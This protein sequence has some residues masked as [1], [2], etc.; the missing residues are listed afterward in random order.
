MTNNLLQQPSLGL[1]IYFDRENGETT[2]QLWFD[3]MCRKLE[4]D[5]E[6]QTETNDRKIGKLDDDTK[7]HQVVLYP[8]RDSLVVYVTI[9]LKQDQPVEVWNKFCKKTMGET[10]QTWQQL[11]TEQTFWGLSLFFVG[12]VESLSLSM[13]DKASQQACLDQIPPIGQKKRTMLDKYAWGNLWQVSGT[14]DDLSQRFPQ[15]YEVLFLAE[16]APQIQPHLINFGRSSLF[17]IEMNLH[18]AYHQLAQFYQLRS[19]RNDEQEALEK[20]LQTLLQKTSQPQ[21]IDP[22]SNLESELN[23]LWGQY[24][25]INKYTTHIMELART[26]KSNARNYRQTSERLGLLSSGLIFQNHL[27]RLDLAQEQLD[28]DKVYYEATLKRFEVGLQT[29]RTNLEISRE[30]RQRSEDK[31]AENL[32]LLLTIIGVLLALTQLYPITQD[33]M[34]NIFWCSAEV[35]YCSSTMRFWYDVLVLILFVILSG[36]A[37]RWWQG[38]K[39]RETG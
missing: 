11:R 3:K 9:L 23:R 12:M 16:Q 18:K 34:D 5:T 38:N 33:L 26:L 21:A 22:H 28:A 31:R 13:P 24:V 15:V 39:P 25:V 1:F 36:W 8:L 30:R 29:V 37:Y 35:W 20:E 6:N 17:F 19:T 27:E 7:L 32:N 4:I 10:W 2:A 14:T